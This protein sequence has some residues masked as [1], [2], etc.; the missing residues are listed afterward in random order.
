VTRGGR[1]LALLLGLNLVNYLDRYVPAAVLPLVERDLGLSH[2]RAGLLG[3]AFVLVYALASP[4]AG[5]L[6]DRRARTR[7]A[8]ASA[9][10][11]GLACFAS[12]LAPGFALLLVFRALTG[13]G[14]AGYATMAPSLLSDVY[15]RERRGWALSIFYTALP[16]GSAL[17]YLVGG[18]VGARAGWRAA[19]FVAAVP[20]L[21]LGAAMLF[22]RE[23]ARGA[24][25]EPA[26]GEERPGLALLLRRRSFLANN[27]GQVLLTFGLG[28]IAFWMPSYLHFVR[29]LP[30]E[31]VGAAFGGLLALAGFLGTLGGGAAS[32]W[33]ARSRPGADFLVAGAGM[34]LSAPFA[35]VA[36][37][38][39]WPEVYW[40]AL[41]V[42]AALVFANTGPLN[43]AI[44]NVVPAT[45]RATAIAWNVLL[46]HLFGD[47]LSPFLLGVLADAAGLRTAVL[48]VS[49]VLLAGG[50]WLLS[51]SRLLAADLGLR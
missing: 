50:L 14:E 28:G 35:V 42:A 4:F 47:A 33:L 44:V 51:T 16:V 17:G 36:V 46:I 23:P 9:L 25:D 37:L 19:F 29:G 48:S 21:L 49:L 13:L 34:A 26:A 39:P 11:F 12:G 20:A 27:L 32:A 15:P 24:L 30:L 6:G 7:I 10:C 40:P 45:L 8:G 3:T 5:W 2:A 41:F 22:A 43:A 18:S 1:L 38:A 31:W